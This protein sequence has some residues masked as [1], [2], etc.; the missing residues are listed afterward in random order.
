VFKQETQLGEVIFSQ[1]IINQIILKAAESCEGKVGILNFKGKYANVVP[2]LA[3]KMNLYH[4]EA[5]GIQIT[6]TEEGLELQIYI[7]VKFGT[8]IKEVT[9]KMLDCIY[10]DMEKILSEKPKKVTITV[11]GMVSKNIAKR[12]IEVSR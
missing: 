9:E 3:S 6:E 7:V 8:S 2:G 1:D 11:T 12:H 5:G 4:E 10:E